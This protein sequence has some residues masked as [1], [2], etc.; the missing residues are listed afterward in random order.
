MKISTIVKHVAVIV[1]LLILAWIFF[2][3]GENWLQNIQHGAQWRDRLL[4][5]SIGMVSLVIAYELFA[6]RESDQF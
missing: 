2:M 5:M 6:K 1:G 4:G 3:G